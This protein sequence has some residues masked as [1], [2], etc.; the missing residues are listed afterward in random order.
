M[1]TPRK[2]ASLTRGRPFAKGNAGRPKGARNRT[3]LAV[4]ALLDGEARK[5]TKKAVALALAGDTTALRLCLERLAP[6]RKDRPVIFDL[7]PI[8]GAKDHPAAI[9]AIIAAVAGGQLTPAEA[10]G[11]ADVLEAH[12]RA[13][14]TS[15][16][17]ERI[18]ALEARS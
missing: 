4:E 16:I 8:D 18:E 1:T 2:N 13:I 17:V 6:P 11:L 14:E 3:T 12:R 10:N 7:P 9:A 5:L 15:E